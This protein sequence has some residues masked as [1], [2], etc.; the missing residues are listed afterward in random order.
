MT[1]SRRLWIF[2]LILLGTNAPLS[3]VHASCEGNSCEE[4]T[5]D[6]RAA[7]LLG[8]TLIQQCS[9]TKDYP[10]DGTKLK[11]VGFRT[12]LSS[13]TKESVHFESHL[14]CTHVASRIIDMGQ[15]FVQGKG[16]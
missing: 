13:L 15:R 1:P 11:P 16:F 5:K 8:G 14:S 10:A 6:A 12:S 7:G 4:Q 2:S 9:K 3:Y